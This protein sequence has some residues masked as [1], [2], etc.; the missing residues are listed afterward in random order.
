MNMK[1][2][3]NILNFNRYDL[4]YFLLKFVYKKWYKERK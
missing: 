2:L 3:F 1:K 4:Y